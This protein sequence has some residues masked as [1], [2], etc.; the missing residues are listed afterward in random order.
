[1]ALVLI[2]LSLFGFVLWGLGSGSSSTSGSATIPPK[3]KLSSTHRVRPVPPIRTKCS[4]RMKVQTAAGPR[5]RCR[6]P[7][8]P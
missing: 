3:A 7:V 6:S 5:R 8:K 1:M 4:A 2:L